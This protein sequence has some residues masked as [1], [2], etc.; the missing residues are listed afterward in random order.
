MRLIVQSTLWLDSTFKYGANLK[1]SIPNQKKGNIQPT[2]T[3]VPH[4]R[5]N[6]IMLLFS[7]V[8]G[9]RVFIGILLFSIGYTYWKR[10]KIITYNG[11][12][13]KELVPITLLLWYLD[14]QTQG[15]TFLL[16]KIKPTLFNLRGG[17]NNSLY[18]SQIKYIW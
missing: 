14:A 16:M 13:T 10:L 18:N 2:K 9:V 5:Y 6:I 7:I 11:H 8:L 15:L 3:D 1:W 12:W 4:I 17:Q